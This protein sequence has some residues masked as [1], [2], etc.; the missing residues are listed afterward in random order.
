VWTSHKQRPDQRALGGYTGR[1]LHPSAESSR[2][3]R[4]AGPCFAGDSTCR[5]WDYRLRPLGGGPFEETFEFAPMRDYSAVPFRER[6]VA[7]DGAVV[8]CESPSMRYRQQDP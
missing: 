5:I 7:S 4:W 1:C 8:T 3:R 2:W 6:F